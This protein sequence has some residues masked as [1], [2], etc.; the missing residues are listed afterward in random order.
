MSKTLAY[1]RVSKDTQDINNQKVEIL[2]YARTHDFSVDD[3]IEV[4]V[5]SQKSRKQRRIDEVLE[6]VEEGDLLICAEL[7]RLGR[8]VV[9]VV[10]LVNQLVEKKVRLIA[11]RNGL[12]ING[13][14]MDMASKVIV[15]TFSMV[16]EL[17]RDFI[18]LRTRE[19][20]AAKKSEGKILGKPKGTIQKSIYDKDR[21][22]IKELLDLGLSVRKISKHLGYGQHMSLNTYINK[23]KLR[24]N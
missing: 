16:G 12:D 19:A 17:E 22:R 8:S 23:R 3:Y 7:T 2:E 1:I 15:Y 5:S 24:E 9:E 10:D 18:S 11:I 21:E 13:H 14:K 20:L 4:E 6:R